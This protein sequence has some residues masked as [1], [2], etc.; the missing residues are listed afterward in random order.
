MDGWA[1]RGEERWFGNQ[2]LV[3]YAVPTDGAATWQSGPVTS[4]AI[5]LQQAEVRPGQDEWVRLVDLRWNSAGAV[6]LRFSLQVLNAQ[7][8]LA[9]QI[10]RVPAG[11][12]GGDGGADRLG[13]TL[14]EDGAAII[15]KL[16]NAATGE[17]IPWQVDGAALDWLTLQADE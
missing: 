5:V 11:V 1:Y 13:V 6:D 2:R 3:L 8:Q 17:P 10:D 15:L 7:G 4:G 9:A 12:G 16:Y 14:P